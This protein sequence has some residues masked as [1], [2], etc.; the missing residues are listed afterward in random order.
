MRK[1][2]FTIV[3]TVLVVALAVGGVIYLRNSQEAKRQNEQMSEKRQSS[4]DVDEDIATKTD[5]KKAGAYVGYSQPAVD[6]TGGRKVLF[7]HASW[8][9]Q[10][11]MIEADIKSSTIPS[12]V[13][14]FK[15]DYD[16]NQELRKEYGVTLQTTFVEIDADGELVDKYVAYSEPTFD[17]L[18][19]NLLDQ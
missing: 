9:P 1:N 18:K 12:G 2:I 4:S 14:I 17:S 8:C 5:D 3:V 15:V 6:S 7:F 10:C 16:T 11:R 19:E 13:T